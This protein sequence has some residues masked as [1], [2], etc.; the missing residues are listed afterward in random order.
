ML[1]PSPRSADYLLNLMHYARQPEALSFPSI[2]SVSSIHPQ[3]SV[4]KYIVLNVAGHPN[5]RPNPLQVTE[6]PY[7]ERASEWEN[8]ERRPRGTYSLP[9]THLAPFLSLK[10]FAFG[11]RARNAF[12]LLVHLS[13]SILP[14]CLFYHHHGWC[15]FVSSSATN[16][17]HITM[18]RLCVIL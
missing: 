9:D 12:P 5:N 13:F 17:I 4:L 8:K 15:S 11:R 3:L 1:F 16:Q 2:F 14:A 10:T 18:I 6:S 7:G